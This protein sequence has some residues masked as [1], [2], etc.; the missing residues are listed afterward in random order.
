[1]S[2]VDISMVQEFTDHFKY[3]CNVDLSRLVEKR[4]AEQMDKPSNRAMSDAYLLQALLA[5]KTLSIGLKNVGVELMER[6]DPRVYRVHLMTEE[7][8]ELVEALRNGDEVAAAHESADLRYVV[9]GTDVT[10][11]FPSSAV[12]RE[13]HRSN[14]TKTKTDGDPRM[15]NKGDSYDPPNIAAIIKD[16]KYGALAGGRDSD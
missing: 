4:S 5:L 15:N 11:G 7:L 2:A 12:F 10:F 9:L 6:G 8:G 14:M 16:W 3:P 13:V 1:M